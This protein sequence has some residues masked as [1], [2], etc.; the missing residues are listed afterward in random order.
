MP[1]NQFDA[2]LR[3]PVTVNYNV[4]L[5]AI[6]VTIFHTDT[7]QCCEEFPQYYIS[8]AELNRTDRSLNDWAIEHI[9]L[10][11]YYQDEHTELCVFVL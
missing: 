6:D 10:D 1:V 8:H 2:A 7:G 4:R 3:Y 9:N 5:N 11:S